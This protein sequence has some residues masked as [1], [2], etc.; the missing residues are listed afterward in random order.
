MEPR[1]YSGIVGKGE[2]RAAKLGFPTINIPLSDAGVSGV[3]AALVKTKGG[4][5]RAVAFADQKRNILEAH[6]I[7][8]SGGLYGKGVVIELH[9]KLR[10]AMR[11]ETDEDLSRAIR[12]DA[13]EAGEY[14]AE[15]P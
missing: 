15:R 2:G 12:G 6:L 4:L 3:Y 8:F 1:A 14:F 7:D 13:A 9:K 11:F 5:F 10:D